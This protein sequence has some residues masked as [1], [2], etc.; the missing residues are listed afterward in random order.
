MMWFSY[1]KPATLLL[2]FAL[3]TIL[4]GACVTHFFGEQGEIHLRADKAETL[5][6]HNSQCTMHN[7][8][9]QDLALSMGFSGSL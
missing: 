2:H 1:K 7:A 9:L 4:I 6:I 5:E 3:L 8:Q